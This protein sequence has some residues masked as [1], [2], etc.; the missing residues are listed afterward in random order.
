MSKFTL[1]KEHLV[2][3]GGLR[4]SASTGLSTG[5][6]VGVILPVV[7][8]IKVITDESKLGKGGLTTSCDFLEFGEKDPT[9]D[10]DLSFFSTISICGT[11]LIVLHDMGYDLNDKKSIKKATKNVDGVF[12]HYKK[13]IK[14]KPELFGEKWAKEV[15]KKEKKKKDR[16]IKKRQKKES[17]TKAAADNEQTLL[18]YINNTRFSQIGMFQ[19]ENEDYLEEGDYLDGEGGLMPKSDDYR[20]RIIFDGRFDDAFN[21][22]YLYSLIQKGEKKFRDD[23]T[24]TGHKKSMEFVHSNCQEWINTDSSLKLLKPPDFLDA[25]LS[26]MKKGELIRYE[27]YRKTLK[28]EH[29]PFKV[30]D[31]CHCDWVTKEYYKNMKDGKDA[32]S[33]E[34]LGFINTVV[35]LLT[36][37][38]IKMTISDIAAHIKIGDRDGVKRRLE[39]MCKTGVINFAG[40]G[41]YFIYSEKKKKSKSKKTSDKPVD[42][43]AELK[44]Y[45]ALLDEGLIDKDDYEKKKDNLLG[46]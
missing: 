21:S 14:Q 16:E 9:I 11:A 46:L 25:L 7:G 35:E 24:P 3:E 44:K 27:E 29:Y 26:L 1:K 5:R 42:L 40:S 43:K 18:N 15:E 32:I 6:I 39:I 8:E 13:L 38:S 31:G 34:Q 23:N 37:K 33:K 41:R 12:K 30:P 20:G 45:K 17:K 10:F 4:L 28:R 22:G 2:I 36:E 19:E